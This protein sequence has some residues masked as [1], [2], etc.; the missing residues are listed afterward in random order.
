MWNIPTEKFDPKGKQYYFSFCKQD[1]YQAMHGKCSLDLSE[2]EVKL[3][4]E[5]DC[6][7]DS[8]VSHCRNTY[9]S[10][11]SEGQSSPILITD[12]ICNHYTVDDGQHRICIASKKGLMLEAYITKSDDVCHVCKKEE[13]IKESIL[14]EEKKFKIFAPKKTIFQKIFNIEPKNL[15]QDSLDREKESLKQHQLEKESSFRQF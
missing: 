5:N 10:I 4:P 7:G 15:Y 12:N 2:D 14:Y 11:I 1:C 6:E 8:K 9:K 13:E 3:I